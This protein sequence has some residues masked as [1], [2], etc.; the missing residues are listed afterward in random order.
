MPDALSPQIAQMCL[1]DI[2]FDIPIPCMCGGP[3][4]EVGDCRGVMLPPGEGREDPGL[5]IL[6]GDTDDGECRVG[7][8]RGPGDI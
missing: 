4:V 5:L 1:V 3:M 2:G 6:P 8:C 7:D